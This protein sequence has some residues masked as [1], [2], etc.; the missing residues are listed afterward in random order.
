MARAKHGTKGMA[1]DGGAMP[2]YSGNKAPKKKADTK[3]IATQSW[4]KDKI[5]DGDIEG[6]MSSGQ[7]GTSIFDPVLCEIAYRWFCPEGGVV[8]DPF[9]GGSVR[10]II[11]SKL[12]RRYFGIELRPEQVE[13]NKAQMAICRGGPA[14]DWR[15]GDSRQIAKLA[16]DVRADLL[17]SC[18]PYWNL[19]VYSDDPADLSTFGKDEFFKAHAQIIRDG[20]ARLRDDRFCVWV[21]G[22]VRDKDGYYANLPGRTIDA[23]EAAGA[24]LYNECILVTACGSLPIRIRKQ[25]ENGRKLGKTHQNILVFCKGDW[26]KACKALGSAEFGEIEVA[27]GGGSPTPGAHGASAFGDVL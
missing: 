5:A 17:F 3:A 11:A 15:I 13:A 9:A 8:L 12:G 18:P 20:V 27:A 21:V 6:G 24:R 2:Q 1:F 10:G 19:E 25:F 16:G 23:F 7:T 4:V 14:P 26:K 22:D